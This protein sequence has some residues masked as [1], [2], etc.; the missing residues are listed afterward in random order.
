YE[1][2]IYLP[3]GWRVVPRWDR[4]ILVAPDAVPNPAAYWT[5]SQPARITDSLLKIGEAIAVCQTT[6]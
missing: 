2:P 4:L 5:S 1:L 3:R 6:V